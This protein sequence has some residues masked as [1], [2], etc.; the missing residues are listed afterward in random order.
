MKTGEAGIKLIKGFEGLR[1]HPYQPVPGDKWTIGYGH[2]VG[3]SR[4]Q[5][6]TVEEAHEFLRQDLRVYESC[7][8]KYVKVAL[9]QNQ[10]DALVSFV[11]NVGCD[12]FYRSTMLRMLNLKQYWVCCQFMR[13]NKFRGKE[14]KGLTR[15]RKSEADLFKTPVQSLS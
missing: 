9:N 8:S 11:F 2:T 1:L 14:L 7:V 10:F 12:A 15:R 5:F 4:G 3:V 13:W 6:I